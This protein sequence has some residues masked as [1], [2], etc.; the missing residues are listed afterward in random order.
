MNAIVEIDQA[1]RI[2]VPKKFRDALHLKPGTRLLVDKSGD[3]LTLKA[4]AG[5]ARLVVEDGVPLVVPADLE[6]EPTLTADMVNDLIA[7]GRLEREHRLLGLDRN[8]EGN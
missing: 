2:V 3:S 4:A 7:Q 5:E 6:G 1:G 8:Q